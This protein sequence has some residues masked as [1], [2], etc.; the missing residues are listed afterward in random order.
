[1]ICIITSPDTCSASRRSEKKVRYNRHVGP[2][3]SKTLDL[4]GS[5]IP[6]NSIIFWAQ[7]VTSLSSLFASDWEI[8]NGCGDFIGPIERAYKAV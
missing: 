1:M 4:S 3:A 8:F 7:R 2:E 5:S 6:I